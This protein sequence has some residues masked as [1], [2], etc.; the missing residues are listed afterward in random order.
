MCPCG[1]VRLFRSVININNAWLS[2]RRLTWFLVLDKRTY[3]SRLTNSRFCMLYPICKQKGTRL[4]S[5][6]FSRRSR[7]DDV[8]ENDRKSHLFSF[9]KIFARTNALEKSAM[10]C[11]KKWWYWPGG[12]RCDML[13]SQGD[14]ST[15]GF[16]VAR[17][18]ENI[19]CMPGHIGQNLMM[20]CYC[21]IQL[22]SSF[23]RSYINWPIS[24]MNRER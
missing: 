17:S 15:P 23:R 16:T 12:L 6:V 8:A 7:L 1:P 19:R 2:A 14:S 11:K 24:A 5:L 10:E 9:A 3:H 13:I 4:P 22:G 20:R 21:I 18:R